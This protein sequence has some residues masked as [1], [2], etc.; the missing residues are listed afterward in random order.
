M[1][2]DDWVL[3]QIEKY[4]KSKGKR[5]KRPISASVKSTSSWAH[6]PNYSGRPPKVS[7][8]ALRNKSFYGNKNISFAKVAWKQESWKTTNLR[9]NYSYQD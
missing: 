4:I 2:I 5:W 9:S 3:T 8:S 7:T 1:D 6:T